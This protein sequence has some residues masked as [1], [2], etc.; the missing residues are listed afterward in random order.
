MKKEA[1]KI[2]DR[3]FEDPARFPVQK[4]IKRHPDLS[5]IRN[6][7]VLNL[8]WDPREPAVGKKEILAVKDTLSIEDKPYQKFRI[9]EN[10]ISEFELVRL[11]KRAIE[12]E[13]TTGKSEFITGL[14]IHFALNEEEN[15]LEPLYE[16]LFMTR[17]NYRDHK[18]SYEARGKGIFI[19]RDD[20]FTEIKENTEVEERRKRYGKNVKISRY[21]PGDF[22]PFITGT[23]VEKVI[24]TFQVIFT[25]LV[26]NYPKTAESSGLFPYNSI[27][28]PKKEEETLTPKKHCILLLPKPLEEFSGKTTEDEFKDKY[29]NRSR[30]CPPNCYRELIYELYNEGD[31]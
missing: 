10:A 6:E 15:K 14:G 8:E 3:V 29:A 19:F 30:L 7:D 13:D 16:P 23:D 27:R 5:A 25:L 9:H 22:S 1:L 2:L 11:Y 26:D 12:G 4:L 28:N 31:E 24:F 18:A 17:L 20:K 21:F